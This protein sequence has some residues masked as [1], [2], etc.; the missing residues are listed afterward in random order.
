MRPYK[1]YVRNFNYLKK[2]QVADF[3][4]SIGVLYSPDVSSLKKGSE[5]HLT[6]F[7]YEYYNCKESVHNFPIAFIVVSSLYEYVMYTIHM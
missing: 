4:H 5:E 1:I 7:E 6:L 2:L 3:F